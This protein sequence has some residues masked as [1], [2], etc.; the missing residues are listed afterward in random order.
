MMWPGLLTLGLAVVF[1][2]IGGWA[3]W[4]F[5]AIFGLLAA[6]ILLDEWLTRRLRRRS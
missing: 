2:I 1:A 4:I 5:A 6:D 3:G